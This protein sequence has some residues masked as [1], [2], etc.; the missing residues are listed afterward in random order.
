MK[1]NNLLLLTCVLMSIFTLRSVH[2]N[3]QAKP[4]PEANVIRKVAD[5]I[6][7]N[8]TYDFIIPKE[9]KIL[10]SVNSSNF[11]K[12]IRIRSPYNA[13]Y[14]SNG[15]INIGMLR[16][17]ETLSEKKYRDYV[18]KN[19]EFAFN[20]LPFFKSNYQ[21]QSKWS[22]PFGQIIVTQEL[23]DCGAMGA[24]LIEVNQISPRKEYDDYL[25][26][27]AD[28]ILQ[29]QTRLADKTLVRSVPHK[30][31]LWADDLYMSVAFLSRMGKVTGDT[32]YFDDAILQVENF[33][34]YL[35]NPSKEL[36][37]HCW[38]SDLQVNGVAHWSRCN[39]WVMMA[40]VELLDQM[41]DNYPGREKVIKILQQ[42]IRGI[43]RYQD[44]SG[45]WHQILDKSDSYLETSGTAIY[46][47]GVAKAVNSGWID[48]RFITI[49]LEGWKGVK[50]NIQ[51]D[52]QIINVCAGTGIEND[53]I[54]Y[55][56]RP[57]PVND[58]HGFGA[59]LLAG[60]EIIK[61]RKNNP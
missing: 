25:K 7:S 16:I 60:N 40:Q 48:K 24:G 30:M 8:S 5:F 52:G 45:M 53:L 61:Y 19:Y 14:Y 56:Q 31:T 15:V 12:S 35:Y 11:D 27:A 33:T 58:I 18:I 26:A 38:Y 21:G 41:P 1:I 42:Q 51:D 32:K 43:A 4:D 20:N 13:W 54:F 49:A 29:K 10:S 46:T 55:Y 44:V 23:D 3:A 2:L 17:A 37:Y 34:K 9:N 22:Y 57:T 36:Y 50:R 6:L 28:H 39:G 59:I 47:Y